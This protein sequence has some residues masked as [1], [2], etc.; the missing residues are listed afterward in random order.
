MSKHQVTLFAEQLRR[1]RRERGLTQQELGERAGL[2]ARGIRALEHGERRYPHKETMQLL[3]EALGLSPDQQVEFEYAAPRV[4]TEPEPRRHVLMAVAQ[5]LP[6]GGFVGALPS[7]PIVGRAME[8]RR[9]ATVAEDVNAGTGRLVVLLGEAGVGKTR[10]AQEATL[11]L[12]EC[13]FLVAGGRCY[14]PRQSTAYHPFLEALENLYRTCPLRIRDD[15][16][17]QW[18][19][20]AHLLPEHSL[21]LPPRSEAADERDRLLRAVAGFV[22]A[23]AAE[24]PVAIVIDDLHWAD[25]ASLD[26]VQHLARNTRSSRV[27]ILATYRDADVRRS[28]RLSKALRDLHREQL[29]DH[30]PIRRLPPEASAE[31]I[32][33]TMHDSE[34]FVEFADLIYANAEGNPFFTVEILRA[35]AERGD[36]LRHNDRWEYRSVDQIVIPESVLD[37]I[38]ERIG[39]LSNEAQALLGQASVLGQ[40]FA[41]DEILNVSDRTEPDTEELIHEAVAL[42]ILLEAPDDNYAFDHVL[43][44][45]TI[46]AELSPRRRR[47]THRAA[48]EAIEAGPHAE[49][50]AAD[51]AHHFIE[52]KDRPRALTYSVEAGDQAES[53]FAHSEAEAH[54]RVA[55][56]LARDGDDTATEARVLEKLGRLITNV[57][58]FDE[59]RGLL[60]RSIRRYDEEDDE[61]GVIRAAVQLGAIHHSAGSAAE[62]IAMIQALTQRLENDSR[63]SAAIE[64]HIVL[65]TLFCSAGR[66]EEGLRAATR[67]ADLARAAGNHEALGR[68]EVGRGAE[69]GILGL[70]PEAL[71]VLEAAIPLAEAAGDIYNLSRAFDYAAAFCKQRGEPRPALAFAE[72]NLALQQQS[73][74]PWGI[75]MALTTYGAITSFMGE[76]SQ[77]RVHFQQ[78]EALTR[79]LGV[80]LYAQYCLA[81]LAE[82]RLDEGRLD[83]ARALAEEVLAATESISDLEFRREAQTILARLDLLEG[84][85]EHARQR[86]G[87]ILDR[88]NLEEGTFT[89]MLSTLA[90]AHLDCGDLDSAEVTIDEALERAHGNG[91]RLFE[92]KALVVRGRL[93]SRRERWKM[94]EQDLQVATEMAAAMP[95]PHLQA[96]ALFHLGHMEHRSGHSTRAVE[97][98]Q[99]A[100]GVFNQLGAFHYLRLTET[101]LAQ[102]GFGT[103]IGA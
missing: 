58:R 31:L 85:P 59:A 64:L 11:V 43:T 54:Y 46:Y 96:R 30:L 82:F 7:G 19:Y 91:T 75:A 61:Q 38:G 93:M 89:D 20:L 36:L 92:A 44:Q 3:G 45:Q 42:G 60:E 65:E 1:Y 48:A 51:L 71:A 53:L 90:T 98:L 87:S 32:R 83:E 27:L 70:V 8:L 35:L 6:V 55:L 17:H 4:A 62:G 16:A 24:C 77:A 78:A 94:A 66:H 97:T 102:S 99:M 101:A 73:Q 76:W 49:R 13:G 74:N 26:L 5:P 95:C 56:D 34:I 2:S 67:G 15:V 37:A 69:L 9:L 12:R 21:P 40:T 18:P 86:I 63:P 72:R 10:L 22:T 39:H 103:S 41:F 50:R 29:V 88:P 84:L 100:W 79:S 25:E 52:A 57:G 23:T 28:H 14:E 81:E 80:S 47:R 33:A 68:A